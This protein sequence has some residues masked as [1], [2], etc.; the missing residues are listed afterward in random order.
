[1][2]RKKR[3][4]KEGCLKGMPITEKGLV[5]TIK[6]VLLGKTSVCG[7]KKGRKAGRNQGRNQGRKENDQASRQPRKQATRIE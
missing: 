4:F 1:M 5:I 2:Q 6:K 7:K 3:I